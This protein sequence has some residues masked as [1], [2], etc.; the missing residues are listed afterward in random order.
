MPERAVDKAISEGRIS[1]QLPYIK[2]KAVE[3]LRTDYP[4]RDTATKQLV[5]GDHRVLPEYVPGC[6]SRP[7]RPGGIR[8][9]T[10]W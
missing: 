2:K 5:S 6:L 7:P 1:Q 9:A 10:S 3:L 8:R 4:D